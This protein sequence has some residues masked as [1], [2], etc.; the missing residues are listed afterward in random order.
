MQGS[1]GTQTTSSWA[2]TLTGENSQSRRS[3]WCWHTKSRTR[4]ISS[5]CGVTTSAQVLTVFMVSMTN[6]SNPPFR[7]TQ[8]QH[9][10]VENLLWCLQCHACLRPHRWEDYVHAWWAQSSVVESRADIEVGQAF[11][12]TRPGATL[13]STVGGPWEGH[14]GLGREWE[15]SQ[16]YLR[17]WHCF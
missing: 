12:G 5:C 17:E 6:V 14:V 7:Q 8:I 9:Q 4:R 1:Q 3:A 13:R 15:G 2:T 16:L 11:G 10:T